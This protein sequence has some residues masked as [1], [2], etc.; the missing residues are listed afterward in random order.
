M[1]LNFGKDFTALR[2]FG[3]FIATLLLFELYGIYSDYHPG[4]MRVMT[5]GQMITLPIS[6]LITLYLFTVYWR[7]ELK[8]NAI[9]SHYGFALLHREKIFQPIEHIHFQV[10]FIEVKN[11]PDVAYISVVI[12]PSKRDRPYPVA[13]LHQVRKSIIMQDHYVKKHHREIQDFNR[14]VTRLLALYP[15]IPVQVDDKVADFYGHI[16]SRE[17]PWGQ[18]PNRQT[19]N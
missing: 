18:L 16:T 15:S 12:K 6:G 14:Q 9:H 4:M 7:I 10:E 8:H 13:A 17:F 11:G 5:T 2:V 1:H 19:A 3:G